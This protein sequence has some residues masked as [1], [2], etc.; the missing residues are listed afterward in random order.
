MM[1]CIL[2]THDS[3]LVNTDYNAVLNSKEINL[4]LTI[5]VKGHCSNL[6]QLIK[7][8]EYLKWQ[9][10][11]VFQKKQLKRSINKL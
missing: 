2:F 5:M 7:V 3:S 9:L 4:S 11:S 8:I 6:P 10:Q 1:M